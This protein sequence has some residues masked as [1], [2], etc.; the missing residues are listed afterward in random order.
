MTRTLGSNTENDLVT[1]AA[2]NLRVLTGLDAVAADCRSAMQA[3]LGEMVYAQDRG[4]PTLATI[5]NQY[6][7]AQFEAA[8]RR[9]LLRIPDVTGVES[10]IVTRDGG[11]V[12]YTATIRTIYGETT[13]NAGL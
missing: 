8:G 9:A 1:D 6:N 13:I 12:R 4:I 11:T 10:I 3:Q 5:W 7:P 2:G